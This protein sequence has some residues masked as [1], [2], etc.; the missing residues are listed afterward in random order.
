VGKKRQRVL[1]VN[2]VIHC[3]IEVKRIEKPENF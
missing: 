1:K 3:E 2:N